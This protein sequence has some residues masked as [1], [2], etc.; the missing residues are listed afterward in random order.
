VTG[1]RAVQVRVTAVATLAVAAVLAIAGVTLVLVQRAALVE[2][3]DDLIRGVAADVTAE[4][5]S[6]APPPATIDVGGDDDTAVQVVTDNGII[7]STAN[8]AHSPP[9]TTLQPGLAALDTAP[10]ADGRFRVL[11]RDIETPDGGARLIVAAALDDV[12]ASI[13]ALVR[14]LLLTAPVALAALAA[15][16]WVVVGRTLHPVEVANRRQ[17]QFVADASHELRT[18]LARMRAELEVDLAHPQSTDP[19]QT[20]RSVLEETDRLQRLVDD[21][22]QL[23][24]T[25]AAGPPPTTAVVDLDDLVLAEAERVRAAGRLHVDLTGL[26]AAQVVGN[27]DGLT[28]AVRNLVDNA[29]RH[30][31]TTLA[32]SL[33]ESDGHAVLAVTDDGP[34]ISPGD[35][36]RVFERFTRLDAARGGDG[37]AGLGLAIAREIVTRHG[38]TIEVDTGYESG[39][40]VVVTLPSSGLRATGTSP[41]ES[42]LQLQ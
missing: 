9:L 33:A 18:P 4:V 13:A 14:S 15:V 24:R 37:G 29:A 26:S 25:D 36:R 41:R 39:A 12:D 2:D 16:V 28:R 20:H 31:R 23:A 10:H 7:T 27:A 40:R 3:I 1:S 11:T 30:A 17:Q 22:L 8:I 21:L 35:A 38:G 32:F 42:G 19:W 34:G 6:A 5:S